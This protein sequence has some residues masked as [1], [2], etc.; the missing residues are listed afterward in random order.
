MATCLQGSRCTAIHKL[1]VA[2]EVVPANAPVPDRLYVIVISFGERELA[3]GPLG[4]KCNRHHYTAIRHNGGLGSFGGV[5]S[6]APIPFVIKSVFEYDPP[7][8]QVF[9]VWRHATGNLPGPEQSPACC[10]VGCFIRP[11]D[12]TCREQSKDCDNG[13]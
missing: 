13:A 6:R 5:F 12:S 3:R 10:G 7:E 11:A 2:D 8:D 9:N 4:I 1:A